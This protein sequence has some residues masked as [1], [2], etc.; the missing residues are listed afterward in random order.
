MGIKN[1]GMLD[2]LIGDFTY[3]PEKNTNKQPT[4][5][6]KVTPTIRDEPVDNGERKYHTDVPSEDWLKDKVSDV[7]KSGR[8]SFGVPR[9]NSTTSYE[10]KNRPV[11]MPLNLLTKVHGQRD[12]QN[13]VRKDSLDYLTDVMG[14]TKKLPTNENGKEHVPFIQ[15]G[16]DGEPW[17]NEGNHRIMAAQKLGWKSMPVNV[18][19][20][21]G[22]E[23]HAHKFGFSPEQILKLH[24]RHK[25]DVRESF[26]WKTKYIN[27]L[28][29]NFN[30]R[31]DI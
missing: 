26:D 30:L 8:N 21:D 22:G 20:H 6:A 14:K 3:N 28:L 13:H 11:H 18:T 9:F 1:E 2:D 4:H 15:V 10:E 31:S 29:E 25:N 17:V 7:K 27:K 12:E 24:N 5:K 19:F 16:H 23:R